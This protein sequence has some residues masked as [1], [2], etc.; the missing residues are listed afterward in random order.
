[1]N[2]F[3]QK[4]KQH[5]CITND[6]QA[7]IILIVFAITGFSTLYSHRFI[8]YLLGINDDSNFFLKTVIFIF[9]ILPIYTL[10]LYFWG[11]VFGQRKF[12]TKFIKLKL[13]LL[14]LRRKNKK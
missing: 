3:W 4:I 12:F 14:F 6:F 13:S 10:L 11:N 2:K 1:M 7:A 5:W 8:D 9:L